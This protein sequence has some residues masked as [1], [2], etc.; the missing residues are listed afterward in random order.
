MIDS[1][2]HP[3]SLIS[4]PLLVKSK[5]SRYVGSRR[6]GKGS[7]T[8][9]SQ[10]SVITLVEMNY[11]TPEKDTRQDQRRAPKRKGGGHKN[12]PTITIA[13]H[14][15]LQIPSLCSGVQWTHHRPMIW[16]P[17]NR[18]LTLARVSLEA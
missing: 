14:Q 3:I 18:G 11:Q 13:L 12:P 10:V 2:T 1:V 17:L 4:V 6:Q 16:T 8:F 9:E 7:L 15:P 5:H